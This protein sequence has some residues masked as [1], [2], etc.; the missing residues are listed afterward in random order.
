GLADGQ[1]I[2]AAGIAGIVCCEPLADGKSLA[3]GVDRL[4]PMLQELVNVAQFVLSTGQELLPLQIVGTDSSKLLNDRQTLAIEIDG[5]I[6]SIRGLQ[7]VADI[8]VAR[9]EVAL[10]SHVAG[11]HRRE[12]LADRERGAVCRERL[13]AGRLLRDVAPG[14]SQVRLPSRVL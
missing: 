13:L 8:G 11:I 9:R 7:R 4:L 3:I 10:P 5:L 1:A 12:L 6:V 2:L 14:E